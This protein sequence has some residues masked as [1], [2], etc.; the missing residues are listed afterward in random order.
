MLGFNELLCLI[1]AV[2][3]AGYGISCL[4]SKRMNAEF[5]RYGLARLQWLIGCLQILGSVG[6]LLGL[7]YPPLKVF[8]SAGLTLM[9]LLA[10][11]VRI[12][13]KDSVF[14]TLPALFFFLLNLYIFADSI[15]RIPGLKL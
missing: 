5:A 4:V 13:I 7:F 10:V 14:A 2:S 1:S 9:M 15:S 3:F 8:T 12:K 11:L 6:L